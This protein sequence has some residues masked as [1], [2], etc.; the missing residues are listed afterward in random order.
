AFA[1]AP[2]CACAESL[3]AFFAVTSAPWVICAVLCDFKTLTDTAAATPT[4]LESPPPLESL[5][6]AEVLEP[7][8]AP[9]WLVA[10][11]PPDSPLTEVW[12]LPAFEAL[13]LSCLFACPSEFFDVSLFDESSDGA[14]LTVAIDS[15]STFTVAS[16]CSVNAPPGP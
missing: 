9:D 14:P 5:P 15:V 8:L 2:S 16:D 6:P 10:V 11:V 13:P 3:T 1:M 7:S 12:L 4:P